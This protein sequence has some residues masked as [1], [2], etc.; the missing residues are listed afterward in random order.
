MSDVYEYI[1]LVVHGTKIALL[2]WLN[3]I[4]GVKMIKRTLAFV[5]LGAAISLASLGL[6]AFATDNAQTVV[7]LRTTGDTFDSDDSG[8]HDKVEALLRK[9]VGL[10]GSL[11]RVQARAGVVTVG[12]TVPDEYALRRALD[13]VS[14]VHGV[15]EVHNAME[16]EFPK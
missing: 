4:G 8:L 13:L 14:G 10:A 7:A 5:S 11:F 9:D 16:I 15:R 3:F 6:T 1:D 12:G 2:P